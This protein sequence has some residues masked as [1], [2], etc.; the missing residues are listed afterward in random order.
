MFHAF[1]SPD[2]SQNLEKLLAVGA[3]QPPCRLHRAG[4]G[5][6]ELVGRQPGGGGLR[7]GRHPRLVPWIM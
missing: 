7:P 4:E 3:D 2:S 6:D 1:I 5:P